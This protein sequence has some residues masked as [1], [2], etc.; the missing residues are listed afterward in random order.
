[1]RLFIDTD[2]GVDDA[3]AI[4]MAMK[5][6][7]SALVGISTV[8]GNVEV[9]KCTRNV[10]SLLSLFPGKNI[11]P[12]FQGALAPLVLPLTTAPEVHGDDGLGGMAHLLGKID[13]K[14]KTPASDAIIEACKKHGK[15]L[16]IACLGPL[17]NI[18]FALRKDAEAVHKVGRM[19]VMGGALRVPGNTGPVAEFNFFVDPHAADE[20]LSSSLPIT[21]LPLDVTQQ[22]VLDPQSLR[23]STSGALRSILLR[24]SKG[25]FEYHRKTE[26]FSGGYAHDPLTVAAAFKPSLIASKRF[27]VRVETQSA[28]T[29]GMCVADLR[30]PLRSNEAGVSVAVEVEV[31][32]FKRF[33]KETF[34]S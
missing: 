18:A 19:L 25:Y 1:M 6:N 10:L 7:T 24:I 31:K 17:T 4:L 8:A 13:V 27:E 11:P 12:V 26:G 23:Q 28:L 14:Q 34:L 15:S 33:F 5:R 22:V 21:L 3:I 16:T 9:D 2:T 32:A 30:H 29:R 20:V